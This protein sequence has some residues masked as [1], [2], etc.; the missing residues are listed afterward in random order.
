VT[1]WTHI[2]LRLE[3]TPHHGE[4]VACTVNDAPHEAE[5]V[6]VGPYLWEIRVRIVG[7]DLDDHYQPADLFGG[8]GIAMHVNRDGRAMTGW[9]EP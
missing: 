8:S 9:R 4:V 3:G 7:M 6:A 2:E 5:I 1:G